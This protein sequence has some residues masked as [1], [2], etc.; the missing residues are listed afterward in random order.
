MAQ[1]DQDNDN[2]QQ[3]WKTKYYDTLGELEKKEKSWQEIERLLRHLVTRLSLAAD[4]RHPP[5]TKSLTELR[6]AV[7]DGKDIPALRTLI[8]TISVE[9]GE[10]DQVRSNRQS[11]KSP[12]RI[13]QSLLNQIPFPSALTKQ[14]KEIDKQLGSMD[15]Y[16]EVTAVIEQSALLIKKMI[17]VEREAAQADL[18]APREARRS[19]LL[20]RIFARCE[21]PPTVPVSDKK[22]EAKKPETDESE[23]DSPK[24]I[25]P[26]VGEL[27]LQLAL[28][29]P[30]VVKKRINFRALK[31]HLN[32]ARKRKDLLPIV[33]VIV[34]N[35][36]AAYHIEQPAPVVIDNATLA[37]LSEALKAFISHMNLP[38]D[39]Q[40][41]LA[42]I[43]KLFTTES[44][45][46]DG[47]VH[48]LNQ[49]ADVV[50]EVCKRLNMH[51][52]ELTGFFQ[53]LTTRLEGLEQDL[54]STGRY[55]NDT[56]TL[57]L[58]MERDVR[59]EISE[60]R[61]AFKN[62]TE[63]EN[64][65]HDVDS[66]LNGLDSRIREFRENQEQ[67]HQE[68]Q[69]LIQQLS[70]KVKALE[71]D[72]HQLRQRLEQT[73]QEAVQDALTGLP[74]RKAYEERIAAEVART[75]RYTTPLTMV[76]W[77]VDMFKTINDTYG[78]AAGDRVLRVIA[79]T[80]REHIRETDFLARYGG[81]EFIL[82]LPQTKLNVAK[83][84][85]DKLRLLIEDTPFHFQEQRVSITISGGMAQYH[86]E[87]AVSQLF[88]RADKA[89]Y[90]AKQNG[91]NRI[92][93]AEVQAS[94]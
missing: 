73:Q 35:I 28:R 37:S 20:E 75:R 62:L 23:F 52:S 2:P 80:L 72:G 29:L 30:D 45:K 60:M 82:L 40:T 77:D 14:C 47:L 93:T 78:H 38:V 27:L 46:I 59:S 41:R 32:K 64:L 34:Q 13:L 39:L 66:R 68:D 53:Q 70:A 69:D 33:D 19:K 90:Q 55:R 89:L 50:A 4:T 10:L 56:H 85:C 43:E 7:R 24:T 74:N 48:C 87:E 92:E 67:R 88:E 51:H 16:T 61:A 15:E 6:A 63:L 17:E 26:A 81:E 21:P 36:V 42:E 22:E 79:D 65:K 58:N 31:K 25:A 86:G 83:T 71:T 76:M 3:R 18:E 49:L 57:V 91:R 12:A 11:L 8:E 9:I 44:G 94:G 5:L 54:Q 1:P 84:V